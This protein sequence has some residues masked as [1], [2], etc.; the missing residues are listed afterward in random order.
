M[1]LTQL[2]LIRSFEYIWKRLL[3][4]IFSIV[5]LTKVFINFH[6]NNNDDHSTQPQ[7]VQHS[8]VLPLLLKNNWDAKTGTRPPAS[9]SCHENQLQHTGGNQRHALKIMILLSILRVETQCKNNFYLQWW[10]QW[11]NEQPVIW[12]PASFQTM[13]CEENRNYYKTCHIITEVLFCNINH[14]TCLQGKKGSKNRKTLT[15]ED[16]WTLLC[17]FGGRKEKLMD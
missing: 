3:K 10:P 6:S 9:V 16:C 8:V 7:T 5:D 2:E 17:L 4:I 11:D 13:H 14:C 1:M 12:V 15:A